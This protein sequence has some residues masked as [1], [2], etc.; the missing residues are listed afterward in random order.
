MSNQPNKPN[1]S[2]E[3]LDDA[4]N[5]AAKFGITAEAAKL[6][7]K[8]CASKLR[9]QIEEKDKQLQNQYHDILR[10][11]DLI[12]DS[13]NS[14]KKMISEISDL[15]KEVERLKEEK[16]NHEYIV[17]ADWKTL[18][19]RLCPSRIKPEQSILNP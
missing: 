15:Q 9:P 2:Q 11:K 16:C 4:E 7:Y 13:D 19:C 1:Y 10:M 5:F 6:G 12:S 17:D 18:T 8:E 3:D 14:L